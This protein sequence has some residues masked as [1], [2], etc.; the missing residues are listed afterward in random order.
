MKIPGSSI[1]KCKHGIYLASPEERKTDV[2]RYCTLCTPGHDLSEQRSPM[3]PALPPSESPVKQ[4]ADRSS[5]PRCGS[6]THYVSATGR[7]WTCSEC[8]HEWKAAR[9]LRSKAV[10]SIRRITTSRESDV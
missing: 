2:A 7:Y 5:C 10:V 1:E 4:S 8:G 3:A 9:H 6:D